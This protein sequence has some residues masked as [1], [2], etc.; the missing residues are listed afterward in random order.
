MRNVIFNVENLSINNVSLY[1]SNS[2]VCNSTLDSYKKKIYFGCEFRVSSVPRKNKF[3]Y[4][5]FPLFSLFFTIPSLTGFS[6]LISDTNSEFHSL[7][8]SNH[9]NPNSDPFPTTWLPVRTS[10][11]RFV[12]LQ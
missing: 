9:Q 12:P 3:T 10:R 7:T 6:F 5:P 8:D 4:C 2:N 1:F 11:S